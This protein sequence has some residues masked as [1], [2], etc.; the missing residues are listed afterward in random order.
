VLFV[1]AACVFATSASMLVAGRAIEPG[2]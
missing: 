1:G 2:R